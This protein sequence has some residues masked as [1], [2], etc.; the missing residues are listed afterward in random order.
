MS[1]HLPT[2]AQRDRIAQQSAD[3]VRGLEHDACILGLAV[4][5]LENDA[6]VIDCGV[7]VPGSWEAGRRVTEISQGG[8]ASARL[9]V[10]EV[11]GVVLPE[12]TV[13]SWSPVLSAYGFQ[14]SIPLI[15]VDP[16]IRISGP[17]L[18]RFADSLL[19]VPR[20]ELSDRAWGIGVIE[21]DQLPSLKTAEALAS[22]SGLLT[23]DLTLIVVPAGSVA[24]ATQIAGRINESVVFT[25][26]ESLGIDCSC[27]S[28]LLGAVPIAPAAEVAA[29][30][31]VTPDDLI[32]YA[33]RVVLT[34]DPE[35]GMDL[36]DLAAQLTFRS[37]P[38]Y[39]R[40]FADLLADAG[41]V[42]E[43][44]PGLVDLNKVAQVTVIDRRTGDAFSTGERDESILC[45]MHRAPGANPEEAP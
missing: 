38:I 2:A 33:G 42:F 22:R 45:A 44:I 1:N 12:L 32:H 29:S 11:A 14:V 40:R 9:G 8:M 4:S 39:G 27:V 28:H 41:G 21:S 17:I 16:A 30:S 31:T 19:G 25:M 37:T 15:E 3:L 5:R 7:N 35:S 23:S 18:A 34:I 36:A 43:A 13:E 10:T 6:A 20:E 26:E 24:G